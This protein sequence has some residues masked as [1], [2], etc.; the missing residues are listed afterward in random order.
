MKRVLIKLIAFIAVA[1]IFTACD[2]WA[3]GI[4]VYEVKD[5]SFATNGLTTVSVAF[6]AGSIVFLNTTGPN[7]EILMTNFVDAGGYSYGAKLLQD[8]DLFT[9]TTNNST[10]SITQNKTIEVDY[11]NVYGVGTHLI[12][13]LPIGTTILTQKVNAVSANVEYFSQNYVSY[14]R[15]A[16]TTGNIGLINVNAGK[17]E[18]ETTTGNVDI[19]SVVC[20][21]FE[22]NGTT[23]NILGE[24][25]IIDSPLVDIQLTTGNIRIKIKD[26]DNFGVV[27]TTGNIET[28][29]ESFLNGSSH[30]YMEAT[31]GNIKALF[32]SAALAN[33]KVDASV[34]VGTI[35]KDA[36]FSSVV[37]DN[38]L[39]LTGREYIAFNG[40]GSNLVTARMTTGN[41]TI[42]DK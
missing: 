11:W 1:G 41:I 38:A 27:T 36:S 30:G 32:S 16:G 3:P 40:A 4:R 25:G 12:V 8:N 22:V 19:L 39:N 9:V 10:I 18:I 34:T 42:D 20:G 15:L 37:K 2:F 6:E 7:V 23:G 24:Q 13:M 28:Y 17:V 29:V 5:Y 26:V 31:S 14:I 35:G 21:H 33:L